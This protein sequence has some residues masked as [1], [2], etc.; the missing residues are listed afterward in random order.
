MVR[1]EKDFS[2]FLA[3]RGPP[4]FSGHF[5]GDALLG[6]IFFHDLPLLLTP[7][8]IVIGAKSITAS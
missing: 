3:D 5:T 4:W 1:I 8:I 2:Y 7:E 6:E